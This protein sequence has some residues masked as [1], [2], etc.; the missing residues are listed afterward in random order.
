M[1]F[2]FWYIAECRLMAHV[3]KYVNKRSPTSTLRLPISFWREP[4]TP[5]SRFMY[6]FWPPSPDGD[7]P[8][9]KYFLGHL[10][11]NA[12]LLKRKYFISISE[13][14]ISFF[15][16]VYDRPAS[17]FNVEASPYAASYRDINQ[18]HG[19]DYFIGKYFII[20]RIAFR[21]FRRQLHI[22]V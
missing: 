12:Y 16:S 9:R 11:R 10:W 14:N 7:W 4:I 19:N 5:A 13:N 21:K 22:R 3:A 20:F 2:H 17:H 18:F 6:L 15:S 1:S 8:W